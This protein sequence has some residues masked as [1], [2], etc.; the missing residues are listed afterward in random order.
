LADENREK[1]LR[2]L[3]DIA[4]AD[5]PVSCYDGSRAMRLLRSQSSP[6]ELERMGVDQEVIKQIWV[7]DRGE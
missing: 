2:A 1:T 7:D 6:E 5:D 4:V 3:I